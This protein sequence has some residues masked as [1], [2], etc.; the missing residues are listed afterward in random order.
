MSLRPGAVHVDTVR[1]AGKFAVRKGASRG[2][3]LHLDIDFD[4]DLSGGTVRL[5]LPCL[6][7]VEQERQQQASTALTPADA[8]HGRFAW[9]SS[10]C[11]DATYVPAAAVLGHSLRKTNTTHDRCS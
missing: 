4:G 5:L 1:G 9:V 10:L 6:S 7:Y 8:P 3:G 11:G 2:R